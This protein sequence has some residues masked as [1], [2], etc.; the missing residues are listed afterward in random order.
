MLINFHLGEIFRC[1]K[2]SFSFFSMNYFLNYSDA[3]F[4]LVLVFRTLYELNWAYGLVIVYIM[5]RLRMLGTRADSKQNTNVTRSFPKFNIRELWQGVRVRD[6]FLLLL[7]RLLLYA[8]YMQ[9]LLVILKSFS[10]LIQK[11]W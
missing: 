7:A 4:K 10:K 11:K 6:L 9:Y 2:F 8:A 3:G 5:L 1:R